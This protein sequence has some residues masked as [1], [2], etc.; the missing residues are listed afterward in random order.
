MF[1]IYFKNYK[2]EEIINLLLLDFYA[3]V[4]NFKVRRFY[5]IPTKEIY[6]MSNN[7]LPRL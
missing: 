4:E 7:F 6:K 2:V 3:F 1:Q 5:G